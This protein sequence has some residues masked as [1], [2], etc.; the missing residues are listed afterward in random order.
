[1]ILVTSAT[2][3]N[4]SEAA[5]Q[6]LDTRICTVRVGARN[7]SK[8]ASLFT[9]GAEAVALNDTLES[10]ISAFTGITAAYIIL[11]SMVGGA[12]VALFH[13]YLQAAKQTSTKH[14]VYMSGQVAG[15]VEVEASNVHNHGEH[16]QHL[17]QASSD[18]RWRWRLGQRCC[19]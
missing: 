19:S 7:P 18:K 5:K 10:A 13:N 15:L 14:I 2:S 17:K 11:P 9:Q 8:L 1:M 3:R 12:E 6:L 16:E 4:G